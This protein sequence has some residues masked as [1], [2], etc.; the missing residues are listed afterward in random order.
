MQRIHHMLD[1]E[2]RIWRKVRSGLRNFAYRVQEGSFP[3]FA[4]ADTTQY[5]DEYVD[6]YERWDAQEKADTDTEPLIMF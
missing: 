6:S 3:A 2:D 1:E 4:D 5:L